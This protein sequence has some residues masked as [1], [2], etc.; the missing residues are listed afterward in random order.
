MGKTYDYTILDGEDTPNKIRASA[1]VSSV[2]ARS[3]SVDLLVDAN[4][5]CAMGSLSL[6][7][8]FVLDS[9]PG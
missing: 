9:V 8:P 6:G 5:L 7:G 1:S 4:P 3:P 2:S